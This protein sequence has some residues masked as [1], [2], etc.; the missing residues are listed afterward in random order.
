MT[1]DIFAPHPMLMMW[2]QSHGHIG[3]E[4]PLR[5]PV[6]T[7]EVGRSSTLQQVE[8]LNHL[9]AMCPVGK[10]DSSRSKPREPNFSMKL[11]SWKSFFPSWLL[12]KLC[13]AL[14]TC[15]LRSEG[16]KVP[17]D[18][19]MLWAFLK[20]TASHQAQCCAAET[21]CMGCTQEGQRH[22]HSS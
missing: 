15:S 1:A 17:Q 20:S 2:L 12:T 7:M 14:P 21:A 9:L 22:W 10:E 19:F 8:C 13:C 4:G 11:P 6:Q 5:S 18:P 3:W 16:S